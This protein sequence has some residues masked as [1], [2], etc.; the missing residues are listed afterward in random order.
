MPIASLHHGEMQTLISA[1]P[2]LA[3]CKWRCQLPEDERVDPT[4]HGVGTPS[5]PP[6]GRGPADLSGREP[7]G[8][9]QFVRTSPTIWRGCGLVVAVEAWRPGAAAGCGCSTD[10]CCSWRRK[11]FSTTDRPSTASSSW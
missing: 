4:G 5:D 8:I 10:G 9:R 3:R 1:G 2:Y 11:M 6:P 7:A